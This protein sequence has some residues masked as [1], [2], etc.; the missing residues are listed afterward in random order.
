MTA[1]NPPGTVALVEFDPSA[2]GSHL[3]LVPQ[4]SS[5]PNEPLNWSTV[6]KWW[7]YMLTM[8]MVVAAF[9][10]VTIQAVFW[11]QIG[12]DLDVTPQQL[13]NGNSTQLAGLAT[14]CI[15]F[16]PFAVK[17]GRRSVYLV[18]IALM[19]AVSWWTA[20]MNTY[21]EMIITNFITGLSGAINET[22]VQMTI[23]DLFF[24]HQRGTAN[25][26]YFVAVMVGSFL[27]I[28][29]GGAQAAVQGWRWSYYSL[30]MALTVLLILFTATFEE[31]KYI[32]SN[33]H[34]QHSSSTAGI[35]T[36]G[37]PAENEDPTANVGGGKNS[38]ETKDQVIHLSKSNMVGEVIPPL[39]S[40][41]ERMRM[42]TTTS[43]SLLR[44]FIAP[45][46]A[47][48]FPHVLFTALQFASGVCWLVL[49]ITMT[50]IVFSA[51]PYN[52]DTSGVGLM[53]LG[54]FVG[55]IFGSIYGGPVSDWSIARFAKRN[56]GT[57]EPEMRLYIML[58]ATL[59]MS[60]G[61]AMFGVTAGMGMHWIYPSV[62]GAFFAA[63]LGAT[64][65]IAFT[66]V[67]DS[68]RDLV[69][70]AF[71]GIAF[72]RNVIS[73]VIPLTSIDWLTNMG[74]VY[75]FVIAALVNLFIGLLFIPMI[76]WGKRIRTA[77]APR[78]YHIIEKR[79]VHGLTGL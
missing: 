3:V 33:P 22:T 45:F 41:K 37:A 42:T 65:D 23:A 29:A 66:F 30:S 34:A 71:V 61:L 62:G 56:G 28:M 40:Y 54:P 67:I 72:M 63:G 44:V 32:P 49:V 17:Y 15:F 31:T 25:G 19:A 8:A 4:P 58:P 51:P 48:F 27:T 73:I 47:I 79:L 11:Q 38:D 68:Y 70:E 46:K 35:E 75:M 78:Y 13:N 18:S 2:D 69:A 12:P 14:G 10:L 64:G 26:L 5:D 60:G 43:E 9:T 53:S 52:F 6:R 39:N 74:V 59:F 24:V 55:N 76:I 77:L 1:S 36:S 20:R 21:T 7:N 57:F 50:S 16:I